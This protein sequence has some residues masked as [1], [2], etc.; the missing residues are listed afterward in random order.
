M[1]IGIIGAGMAGLAAAHLL[2]EQGKTVRV[3]DK[4][5][6]PG[7]RLSTRRAQTDLGEARFD[8]GA[9]FFTARDPAF[10]DLVQQWIAAGVAAEWTGNFVRLGAEG[11]EPLPPKERF[12]GQPGMNEIIRAQAKL[13][14]VS[15]QRRV[16]TI[17]Q[18]DTGWQMAFEDGS[19][20]G[21]F[22]AILVAVPAEQVSD[23]IDAV[24]PDLA[25]EARAVQSAPCWTV[26]ACFEAPLD[27]AWQG[28]E[29][30]GEALAWIANNCSKPGR[31]GPEAWVLQASVDWSVA[32]LED[33]KDAVCADLIKTFRD[34]T[35][36]PAPIFQSAHRWRYARTVKPA[37]RAIAWDG[38][39]QLGTCGDWRT[40]AR[41]EDA[42]LSGRA[43][44]KAALGR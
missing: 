44:A 38:A 13:L 4:G 41:I 42:W 20:E 33:D 24:A 28:A 10:R 7:G 18:G 30:E 39:L 2:A 15:W 35:A 21:P 12:V 25:A 9:Q 36:A 14:D 16:Q 37:A 32:H 29:L 8:H 27:T 22:E 23:L 43:L 40:G 19:Q 11:P 3:F 31:S 6:G 17:S 1:T 5:R 26:M 34:L